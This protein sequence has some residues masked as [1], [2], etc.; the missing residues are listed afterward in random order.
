[1]KPLNNDD[2][3]CNYTTSNCVVWQGPDLPCISLCKGDTISEVIYKMAKELCDILDML[4]IDAYDLSCFNL[5]VCPP[6]DFQE[7]IQFL[8]KRI[9]CLESCTGCKPDCEGNCPPPTLPDSPANG[10][11]GCPDCTVKIA[12]CFQ[13]INQFGDTVTSMQLTDYVN[14]IG[15]RLCDLADLV[16]GSQ[17][18]AIEG[19][20]NR[21][22]QLENQPPAIYVP[23]TVTPTCVLPPVATPMDQVL[24][25]LETQF[26][27]LQGATGVPNALYQSIGRQCAGLNTD[28]T[29]NGSGGT[30]GSLPGW[31]NEVTTV[32]DSLTN[33]WLVICDIRTAIKNI[34]LNCCPTGCDGVELRMTASVTGTVLTVY[35]TGTIPVGVEQCGSGT[36]I[37]VKDSSGNETSFTT[38]L[39]AELNNPGGTTFGLE[40]TPINT[41]V[42]ITVSVKPCLENPE[43]DSTCESCLEYVIVNSALCPTFFFEVTENTI[44][45][46]F[47]SNVGDYTYNVQL[48][49]NGG[50]VMISNQIHIISGIQTVGGTFTG[51]G[52]NTNFRIRVVIQPTACPECEP[53]SCPFTV[54]AT[55][56]ASCNP[57]EDVVSQITIDAP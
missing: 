13:Y 1:M 38:D 15:N 16:T 18:E 31:S 32:A 34:Q 20:T 23:P 14:A 46:S 48:W 56:P 49:D 29:L 7:L 44:N 35:F 53:T 2:P 27:E 19:N 43:T 25:A 57:P 4:D 47:D 42:N 36:I 52:P 8:I 12:K 9:C 26:C 37:R 41:S 33:M 51:L 5:T 50:G 55:N 17:Q 3:G 11:G 22:T 39:I 6:K 40:S 24:T 28:V 30:M 54:V 21:I 10:G 45:Y